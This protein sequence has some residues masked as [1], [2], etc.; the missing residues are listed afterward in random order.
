MPLCDLHIEVIRYLHRHVREL[1][2][3]LRIETVGVVQLDELLHSYGSPL[4]VPGHPLDDGA[5]AVQRLVVALLL[6]LDQAHDVLPVLYQLREVRR[7]VVDLHRHNVREGHLQVQGA[8]GAQRPADQHSCEVAL[9]HVGRDHSVVEHERQGSAVVANDVDVL[10]G[11]HV[12]QQLVVGDSQSVGGPLAQVADIGRGLHV[13][14]SRDL[15]VLLQDALVGLYA[16]GLLDGLDHRP[17]HRLVRRRRPLGYPRRA[18]QPVAGVHDGHVHGHPSLRRLPVLHE[19]QGGQL[20]ALED[21]LHAGTGVTA[22][23]PPLLNVP[24]LLLLHAEPL[25]VEAVA[26]LHRPVLEVDLLSRLVEGMVGQH[27]KEGV[28][29]SGPAD[30]VDIVEAHAGLGDGQRV[31]RRLHHP[32]EHPGLKVVDAGLGEEHVIAPAG[33]DGVPAHAAMPVLFEEG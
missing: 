14:R 17:E 27:L 11:A 4:E 10:H 24:H 30:V 29:P 8:H 2:D 15:G 26:Q 18:F 19:D 28:V 9:A 21:D 22:T 1:L 7:E 33:N 13:H 16:H 20:H 3:Y 25:G 12:R 5:A 31:R 23:L 32:V 6:H